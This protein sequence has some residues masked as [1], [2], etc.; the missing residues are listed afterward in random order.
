MRLRIPDFKQYINIHKEELVD[1]IR[2]FMGF[3]LVVKGIKFFFEYDAFSK[4]LVS[5][6]FS[7]DFAILL[8]SHVII[9]VHI[10]GGFFLM[11]GF[12]TKITAFLQIPIVLGAILLVHSRMDLTSDS[13]YFAIFIL[14]LSI[15]FAL[16]GSGKISIDHYLENFKD[17]E[18]KFL[19]RWDK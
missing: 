1:L 13:F 19:H 3:I 16:H 18:I 12:L 11:L 4:L 5:I 7:G 8:L 6:G 17:H 9:V 14:L 15:V 2:I 10:L